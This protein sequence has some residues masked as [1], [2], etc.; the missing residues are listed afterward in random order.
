MLLSE[1]SVSP[2]NTHRSTFA[3]DG[4]GMTVTDDVQRVLG[5]F[6]QAGKPIGL[7]VLWNST[8][9]HVLHSFA[10]IPSGCAVFLPYWLL[11]CV[12]TK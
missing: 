8:Y 1:D 5:E 10:Y 6:H 3:V 12:H 7:G 9:N 4:A 2:T 11:R